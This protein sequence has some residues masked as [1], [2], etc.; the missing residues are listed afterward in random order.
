MDSFKEKL[1]RYE[2]LSYKIDRIELKLQ[3]KIEELQD[4]LTEEYRL[5]ERDLGSYYLILKNLTKGLNL[6]G[7]K[8]KSLQLVSVSL[9]EEA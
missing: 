2:Q 4:N 1:A 6:L 5:R 7:E 9:G 8:D 3:E